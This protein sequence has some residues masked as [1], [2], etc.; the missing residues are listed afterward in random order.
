MRADGHRAHAG[1]AAAVRDA[2]RLVQVQVRHIR[3]ERGQGG[4]PDQR[5]QVRAVDVHLAARRV[6]R[7]ADAAHVLLVDAGRGRIGQHDGRHPPLVGLQLG[8]QVAEVDGAVGAALDHRHAQ[9]GQ[10]GA[11]RVGAVRRLRDQADV[12]VVLA[13]R[14]M[15]G[16]DGEQAGQFALGAG[17]RLYGYR[18]VAGEPGQP[19]LE[20]FDQL[21]VAARLRRSGRTGAGRRTPAS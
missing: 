19:D 13:A 15:V 16:P 5:V 9:P 12:A 14:R 11:G 18:V 6:H 4:H 7:V 1:T 2:E 8:R 10:H 3:A 21:L 17:V 20:R